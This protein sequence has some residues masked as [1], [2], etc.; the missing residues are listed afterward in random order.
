M[1]SLFLHRDSPAKGK[2]CTPFFLQPVRLRLRQAQ[3]EEAR[4]KYYLARASEIHLRLAA[5]RP[6]KVPAS[7]SLERWPE[8]LPGDEPGTVTESAK[9]V[10]K[11]YFAASRSRWKEAQAQVKDLATC[12]P[13]PRRKV[14]AAIR[15][16]TPQVKA[17]Y[18]PDELFFTLVRFRAERQFMWRFLRG[19]LI[20]SIRPKR[21]H[22][23]VPWTFGDLLNEPQD[24]ESEIRDLLRAY[25]F[26]GLSKAQLLE[27][28]RTDHQA[29][30][31]TA[32]HFHLKLS[33]LRPLISKAFGSR[34]D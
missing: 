24:F 7:P 21:T 20:G 6:G 25:S 19:E 13:I 30:R 16:V 27:G 8:S 4:L 1:L 2:T 18:A 32:T 22:E 29:D 28:L 3:Y 9:A 26:L 15:R 14:L 5:R 12:G 31:E 34:S 33:T 17:K 10:G 11:L 23:K